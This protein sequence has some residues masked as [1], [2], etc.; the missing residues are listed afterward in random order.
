M[1]PPKNNEKAQLQPTVIE[2]I[3]EDE[4]RDRVFIRWSMGVAVAAHLVFFALNW[5]FIAFGNE[6]PEVDEKEQIIF[7]VKQVKWTPPERRELP[8]IVPPS[9]TVPIPDQTPDDPEPIRIDE[10]EELVIDVGP[11]IPFEVVEA[12]PF[13]SEG[14]V[15]FHDGGEMTRP[16]KL[17]GLNPVYPEAARSARIDG[18]VVLECVIGKD[19]SVS[20]VK[21][22]RG[23]PLG[24]TESAIAAVK[25]WNFDPATLHGR[26]VEVLY[27]LTVRF[28]LK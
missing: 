26:P 10:P 20:D 22:L 28:S 11:D 8:K 19:G 6:A 4:V 9:R 25:T 14:I 15:R 23:L 12:P 2:M 16:V 27:I 24:L 3:A 13:E 18:I 21:M 5:S 17:S 1:K 7:I